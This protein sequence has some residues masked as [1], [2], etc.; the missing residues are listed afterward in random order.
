[1]KVGLSN[2][3]SLCVSTTNNF[4]TACTDIGKLAYETECLYVM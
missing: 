1:M 3:Q 4:W 2:H